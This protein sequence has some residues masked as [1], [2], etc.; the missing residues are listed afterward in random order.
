M[1]RLCTP[2]LALALPLILNRFPIVCIDIRLELPCQLDVSHVLLLL[3]TC[4][5]GIGTVLAAAAA[6]V[7]LA[8]VFVV[9]SVTGHVIVAKVS[10]VI[11]VTIV[12]AVVLIVRL[13]VLQARCFCDRF[14]DV[15]IIVVVVVIGSL[16]EIRV[17]SGIGWRY[18]LI[19]I[20]IRV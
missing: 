4:D 6:V 13:P 12:L 19:L 3:L 11:V 7:V 9:T 10:V 8:V 17:P 18:I 1:I 2:L 16:D 20:L 15:L 14:I 5:G